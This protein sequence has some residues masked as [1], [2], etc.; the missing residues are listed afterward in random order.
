VF[1]EAVAL[2]TVGAIRTNDVAL[3]PVANIA[4]AC[5]DGAIFNK[6]EGFT[7]RP[8]VRAGCLPPARSSA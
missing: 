3:H 5:G 4:S 6:A 7:R 1:G 2:E 8:L